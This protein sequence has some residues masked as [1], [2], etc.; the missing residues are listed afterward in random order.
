MGCLRGGT[1]P[2]GNCLRP[3]PCV[4]ATCWK[5][6]SP[7]MYSLSCESCSLFVFTYCH[8]AWTMAERLCVCSPS[9]RARRGSSLNWGGWEKVTVKMRE[10]MER[11]RG[12]A[13]RDRVGVGHVVT[14]SLGT[15]VWKRGVGRRMGSLVLP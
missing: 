1:P 5:Y 15:C 14:G 6:L 11:A 8:R 4:Q 12:Q 9:S 7:L 10:G 2:A 3:R 13:A